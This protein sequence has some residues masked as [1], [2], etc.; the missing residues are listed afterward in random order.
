[1]RDIKMNLRNMVKI[2]VACLVVVCGLNSCKKSV[3][4]VTL[5]KSVL[6]LEIGET[7]VLIANVLPSNA[8]NQA[9]TWT[10]GNPMIAT[11][12]PNGIVTAVAKG[13]TTIV[14]S[15][16]DG[17]KTAN[18]VVTVLP[19]PHPA[20][21]ELVFVEGGTFTMGCTD[22][23]CYHDG[24]EEPAHQVTLSS[25]K[26]A[27]YPV[28]QKQWVIIMGSNPS[29]PKGDNL[30]VGNVDW[31]DIQ[32]FIQKLNDATGK[33]YRLPTEAEWEYAARGGNKSKG[34]KYS[35]SNDVNAVAWY[36]SNSSS[37][38]HVVGTKLPNELGIYDMSGLVAERCGDWYGAYTSNSQTNPTGPVTGDS[39]PAR[40]G[41]W[42]SPANENR[43]SYRGYCGSNYTRDWIGFRLVLP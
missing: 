32:G 18:C 27:K 23:E 9:V 40:G 10:S 4:D 15:T 16:Q 38:S 22:G 29:S 1:M 14:V 12:L 28:T 19:P 42:N 21:P 5:N 41:A 36:T 17:G 43:V 24:R 3:T 26:I 7:A 31:Y 34:Y 8:T 11:V 13:S 37:T 25:Y 30:P 39:Q 35:G 20:E 6:T 2:G 33:N